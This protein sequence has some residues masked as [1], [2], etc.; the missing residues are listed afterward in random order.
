MTGSGSSILIKDSKNEVV[1]YKFDSNNIGGRKPAIYEPKTVLFDF[2]D[3]NSV[4]LFTDGIVDQIGIEN[5]KGYGLKQLKE[6]IK[7]IDINDEDSAKKVV[8]TSFENWKG[9]KHQTD[10]ITLI[11]IKFG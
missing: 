3:I 8:L 5:K 7:T 6:L 9:T 11:G 2:K 1:N 4:F 10:D